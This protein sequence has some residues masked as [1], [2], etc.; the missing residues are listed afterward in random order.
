MPNDFKRRSMPTR[1]REAKEEDEE[2]FKQA[3]R[4]ELDQKRYN[5]WFNSDP[6]TLLGAMRI[7]STRTKPNYPYGLLSDRQ[8][9]A[10]DIRT[11]RES[12]KKGQV[13]SN[14]EQK[15]MTRE[16]QTASAVFPSGID[17]R[18]SE[19]LVRATSLWT[20]LKSRRVVEL[21]GAE[22]ATVLNN[23][24]PR[25]WSKH[26]PEESRNPAND[27]PSVLIPPI[28]LQETRGSCVA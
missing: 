8:L 26:P 25:P 9:S 15:T 20:A 22:A 4:A 1:S 10:P 13:V 18:A 3:Y 23:G 16:E 19:E 6:K 14:S 27:S 24:L 12:L 11:S 2:R 21:E 17:Q 7:D 28:P 5:A